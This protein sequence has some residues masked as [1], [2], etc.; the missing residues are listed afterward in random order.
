MASSHSG[1]S[2]GETKD[3][4]M[5]GIHHVCSRVAQHVLLLSS[6][7]YVKPNPTVPA[8]F[9]QSADSTFQSD[10]TQKFVKTKSSCLAPRAI[11]LKVQGFS[12]AMGSTN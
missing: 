7:N 8:Q 9:A 12:E 3:Y 1:Q 4:P 5:Q 2:G 10:S 11:A 6:G